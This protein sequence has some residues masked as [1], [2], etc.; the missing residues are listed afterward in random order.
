MNKAPGDS[1]TVTVLRNGTE[2]DIKV[3]LGSRSEQ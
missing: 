2:K 3:T 1:V